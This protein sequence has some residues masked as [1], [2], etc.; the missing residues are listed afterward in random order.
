MLVN[1]KVV[2]STIKTEHSAI[3]AR[4]DD[5]FIMDRNKTSINQKIRKQSPAANASILHY[6]QFYDWSAIYCLTDAQTVYNFL[7]DILIGLLDKYYPLRSVTITSRDLPFM[8]PYLKLL[9][10]E[11]NALMRS[12]RIEQANALAARIGKAITAFNSGWLSSANSIN[13]SHDMW[14]KVRKVTNK[15]AATSANNSFTA[16]ALN[17][18]YAAISSDTSYTAPPPK[19]SCT[20]V[21]QWPCEEQ[22]FKSL[23]RLKVTAA[24]LDGIPSWYL[25]LIAAAICKPLTHALSLSLYSSQP[26]PHNGNCPPSLLSIR[27]PNQPPVQIFCLSHSLPF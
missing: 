26:S 8:T 18:H 14:D 21:L 12:G 27:Y 2:K 1:I 5:L 17:T 20:E 25:K 15:T 22:I 24:G 7:S 6:L 4:G 3:I 13:N 16:E 9:L 23:D 19:H 11:K 10:R